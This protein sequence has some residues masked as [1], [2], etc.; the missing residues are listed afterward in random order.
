MQELCNTGRFF[1]ITSRPFGIPFPREPNKYNNAV[2]MLVKMTLNFSNDAMKK[3]LDILATDMTYAILEELEE[4]K[5]L[6]DIVAL[7]KNKFPFL[8]EKAFT[9]EYCVTRPLNKLKNIA[10]YEIC[11]LSIPEEKITKTVKR[12]CE[13]EKITFGSL[14]TAD[15]LK[16]DQS[17]GLLKSRGIENFIRTMCDPR[18]QSFK[19]T[20]VIVIDTS[21]PLSE[22]I[23]MNVTL[24]NELNIE[25]LQHFGFYDPDLSHKRELQLKITQVYEQMLLQFFQ[26]KCNSDPNG[27]YHPETLDLLTLTE[28]FIT[29]KWD[30]HSGYTLQGLA[31]DLETN[32]A[33]WY[34]KT[35]KECTKLEQNLFSQAKKRFLFSNGSLECFG[36]NEDQYS[37]SSR[38]DIKR[39]VLQVLLQLGIEKKMQTVQLV[40]DESLSDMGASEGNEMLIRVKGLTKDLRRCGNSMIVFDLDSLCPVTKH[41]SSLKG[42]TSSRMDDMM[43]GD[44]GLGGPSF[45][46]NMKLPD[47]FDEVINRAHSLALQNKV[48]EETCWVVFLTRHEYITA[49]LKDKLK[50]PTTPTDNSNEMTRQMELREK[51]C[52]WCCCFYTDSTNSSTACYQHIGK[53]FFT[54]PNSSEPEKDIDGNIVYYTRKRA[55]IAI[56]GQVKSAMLC[57]WSCCNGAFYSRGEEQDYHEEE[58]TELCLIRERERRTRD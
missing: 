3:L 19:P 9:N 55:A 33:L 7:M 15:I 43:E 38:V 13:S 11:K 41:I 51:R 39:D 57:H 10:Y 48:T 52:K 36:P 26:E 32:L 53:V 6:E 56:H 46:Y 25:D 23:Q 4:S 5:K 8:D 31:E 28:D 14:I 17:T 30:C 58:D 22:L 21:A 45:Q 40:D 37:P 1:V 16:T 47:L 34:S 49:M 20:G 44:G 27:I 29:F 2:E 18:Q 24:V 35:E 54:V 42:T 50:W 12:L